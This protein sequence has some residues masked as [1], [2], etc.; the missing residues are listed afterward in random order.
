MMIYDE[1]MGNNQARE[2]LNN[3][4]LETI[5]GIYEDSKNEDLSIVFAQKINIITLFIGLAKAFCILEEITGKDS[6][7]LI[8]ILKNAIKLE[9]EE[10]K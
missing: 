6:D 10:D 5:L 9:K 7:M 8:D 3:N 4:N 1:Y 2:Y